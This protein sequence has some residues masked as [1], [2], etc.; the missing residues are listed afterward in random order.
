MNAV[1]CPYCS[2]TNVTIVESYETRD[3]AVIRCLDCQRTAEIDTES[4][5]V[6]TEDLP[7]E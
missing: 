6:D 2:S 3:V 7:S 5:R 4:F 1:K